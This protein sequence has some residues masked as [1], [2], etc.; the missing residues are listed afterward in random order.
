MTLDRKALLEF[1]ARQGCRTARTADGHI[2]FYDPNGRVLGKIKATTPTDRGHFMGRLW[3][4]LQALKPAVSTKPTP[5]AK[6]TMPT[7]PT[8]LAKP[9]V[10]VKA[11]APVMGIPARDMGDT[12]TWQVWMAAGPRSG[13][14]AVRRRQWRLEMAQ[15]R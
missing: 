8:R 1:A 9:V 15:S 13:A 3:K 4:R 5:P 6:L 2:K 14:R 10:P 7:K 11:A 12:I